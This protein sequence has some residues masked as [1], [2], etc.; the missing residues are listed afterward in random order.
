MDIP[1][2]LP[3]EDLNSYEARLRDLHQRG[4]ITADQ[5]F[6][7]Y[8]RENSRLYL[9]QTEPRRQ[10]GHSG[11]L[12]YWRHVRSMILEAVYY[13]GSFI[14]VGCANGHLIQSLSSW[15]K[16]TGV[17]VEFWFGTVQGAL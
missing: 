3:D 12:Y 5:Y 4:R 9:S 2:R 11:D 16:N 1:P 17:A 15:M 7:T 13:D 14:D 6:A 10:S 8:A